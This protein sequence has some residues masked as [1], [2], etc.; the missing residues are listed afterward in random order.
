MHN[1]G[2]LSVRHM[3]LKMSDGYKS[4]QSQRK[5]PSPLAFCYFR[6]EKERM[7]IQCA[8]VCVLINEL[9]IRTVNLAHWEM[10]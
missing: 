7:C 3:E 1:P 4:L 10:S 8:S 2:E 5:R 9:R 6:V